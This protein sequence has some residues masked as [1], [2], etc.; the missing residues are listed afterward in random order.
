MGSKKHTHVRSFLSL[1]AV[2]VAGVFYCGT[3]MAVTGSACMDSA[4]IDPKN[5]ALLQAALDECN[6]EIAAQDA[7]V[8]Q[9]QKT[10]T[11]LESD[12]AVLNA[13]IAR[14]KLLIKARDMVIANLQNTIVEKTAVISTLEE[15]IR[16]ERS[17]VAQLLRKTNEIDQ[18]SLPEVILSKRNL[19]DFF[20][21]VD[22]FNSIKTALRDSLAI[23][24]EAKTQTET[25]K[26][27][28]EDQ[29]R[30]EADA[31]A[32]LAANQRAVQKN[33]AEKKELL[34][35]TKNKEK[36]YQKV[37]NER[38][39]RAAQI[40]AALFQL[41]D[42]GAIQFG[43]AYRYAFAA[44]Q[45][46]GVR[47]AFILAIFS[48]ES[49]FGANQGSCFLRN[50]STGAGVGANTGRI[51][52]NVMK[53]SRDVAPFLII[54]SE[55]GRDPFN[56]RV[57]CPQSV[58]YGGAMGPAQFIPSTW[59]GLRN[60]VASALGKSI[61]N[62][63]DPEDAFMASGIFLRDLGAAGGAYSAERDAACRYFSGSKCSKSSLVAGY[64]NSV[65]AKATNIQENMIDPMLAGR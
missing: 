12:V 29:K 11:S 16:R 22:S 8:K 7:L 62:P 47:A 17:S 58:G 13:Q 43:D 30:K 27:E 10:R 49:S 63:W 24:A 14:S 37:L 48:Q 36:E 45:K 57:S 25:E 20:L 65:M 31:R 54:T 18:S 40:S 5:R 2:M 50:Q 59:M 34:S 41:R 28:L 51:I 44:S 6:K 9:T 26:N 4:S 55:L 3:A 35:I 60:Q 56:T 19:S 23:I 61:T 42:T 39:A 1:F 64:G 15:K 46:T 32:E 38:K 52:E 21:D 33:E 53:P